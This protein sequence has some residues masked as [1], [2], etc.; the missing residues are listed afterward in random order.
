M[1]HKY[2]YNTSIYFMCLL[3]VYSSLYNSM[4]FSTDY[5][6]LLPSVIL[7]DLSLL[8]LCDVILLVL[9]LVSLSL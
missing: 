7:L 1:F 5:V 3:Y 6:F 8:V 9:Q 2:T 4:D